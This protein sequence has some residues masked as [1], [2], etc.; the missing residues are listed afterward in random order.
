MKKLLALV[1]CVMMV[2]SLASC[3][4]S[5]TS[6]SGSGDY[7]DELI[8]AVNTDADTFDPQIMNG[9]T[10]DHIG[11]SVYNALLKFDENGNAI[12]DLA[13][14]WSVSEDEKTWT[15][16]LKEGVKFHS[17]K[18][19]TADDVKASYDRAMN[20]TG[21]L[22]TTQL[23]E[24]FDKVEVIDPYTV[25]IT[26]KEPYGPMLALMC[27]K[28]L[29][30]MDSETIDK[31][32]MEIGKNIEAVNGTGPYKLTGWEIDEEIVLER[33]E[34][35]FGDKAKTK[36]LVFQIIPEPA[37]RVIALETGEVDVITAVPSEEIDRLKE[38]DGI[39]VLQLSSIGQRLFR[40]GCNDEI[41]SNTKVRQAI[42][43]AV[44]RQS[45]IDK[46]F[47]GTVSPST[48]PFSPN[49]WGYA[50]LGEIEQ[51]L[52]KAKALLKEAGY[53]DGF[54][55]KIVTTDRY[56]K[57]TQLAEVVA[58]QL[59]EVGI[60]AEIEVME[61]SAILATWNG[62]TPEEFDEPMFIMGAGPSMR[63]PDSSLRALYSTA[64]SGIND[65]NYG[66]YSNKELDELAQ[67]QMTETD[68][69]KRKELL[70]RAQEIIYEED[71][72]GFWLFDQDNIIATTD[73]V[74]GITLDASGLVLPCNATVKKKFE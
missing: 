19:M 24:M 44:N 54:D 22:K 50:N 58:S 8:I 5:T 43:Y 7:D 31:Y 36:K 17:G 66:F 55:T 25:A 9:G 15:F 68:E 52:D 41:M 48:A 39:K 56:T 53:P 45:I 1:I 6:A 73:K 13:T 71:P 16:K 29:A 70:K 4:N 20:S 63:D 57:G 47:V 32:G 10:G 69:T 27:N 30:V 33:Y 18:E 14:E 38:T 62:I 59:K 28:S 46:L 3:Q 61:W 35:Y 60:N 37:A 74:E 51:D 23:I 12:G 26:T 49:V 72:V 2:V 65:Q 67:Q 34:D 42:N 64:V 21:G 11:E 40:F